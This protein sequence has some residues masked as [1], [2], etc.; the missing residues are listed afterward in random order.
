MMACWNFH[1]ENELFR[2]ID[3]S[4]FELVTDML[5]SGEWADLDN[6]GHID[7]ASL[8]DLAFGDGNGMFTAVSVANDLP[9]GPEYDVIG[10]IDYDNG[11]FN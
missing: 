4:S 8:P 10:L 11:W 5:N 6:D 7:I 1:H 3:G 2:N 9:A